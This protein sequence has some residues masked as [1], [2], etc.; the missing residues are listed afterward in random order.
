[1][2]L[3]CAGEFG[4]V[5]QF[6]PINLQ[7]VERLYTLTLE[8]QIFGP[9]CSKKP[10]GVQRFRP[11]VFATNSISQAACLRF[12]RQPRR[13]T[14]AA[15]GKLFLAAI[16]LAFCHVINMHTAFAVSGICVVF[17]SGI[18]RCCDE[19]GNCQSSEQSCKQFHCALP[20]CC[21]FSGPA[22]ASCASLADP[23][24][25]RTRHCGRIEKRGRD[26]K[27]IV[28]LDELTADC[29]KKKALNMNDPCGAKCPELAKVL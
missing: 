17:F 8:P 11:R 25:L 4:V 1:V 16:F 19:H 5:A 21:R 23:T 7:F 9:P 15:A 6:S 10:R 22:S 28:W 14:V 27:V 3:Y 2:I 29:A 12:L 18:S 13:L 26:G 24:R 20:Q